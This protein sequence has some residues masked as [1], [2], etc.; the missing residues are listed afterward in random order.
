M[1]AV[2]MLL[3]CAMLLAIFTGVGKAD[4]PPERDTKQ[5]C[6]EVPTFF[7]DMARMDSVV[8]ELHEETIQ[9]LLVFHNATPPVSNARYQR[10]YL[11]NSGEGAV[12]FWSSYGF[13]CDTTMFDPRIWKR[14]KPLIEGWPA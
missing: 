3:R 13:V 9:P 12:I 5:A 6:R 10:G 4:T 14:L 11:V 2:N 1:W 8:Y 7:A